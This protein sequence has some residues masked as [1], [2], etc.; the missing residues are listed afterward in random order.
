[1]KRRLREGTSFLVSTALGSVLL[2]AGIIMLVTPGPGI[3]T[4]AA[5]IALLSRHHGWARSIRR[6]S[7]GRWES[8]SVELQHGDEQQRS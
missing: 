7:W 8:G 4:I 5:A 3:L 1:M 6:R 2:V